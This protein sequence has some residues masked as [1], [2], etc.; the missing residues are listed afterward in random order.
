VIDS[1]IAGDPMNERIRWIKITREEVSALM[2]SEGISVSRNI[3]GKL[4]KAHKFVKRKMRGKL[5]CGDFPERN[6]QFEVIQDKLKRF[7]DSPNPVLSMDTKKKELLGRL[8]RPGKVYCSQAIEV[9]DHTNDSL[10]E[11][12]VVPHGIYD[13]KTGHAWINIGT[14]HE[15]AEFLCDSLKVWWENYGKAIYKQAEEILIFCDSGGANSWRI[16]V[17]KVELQKLCNVL[18]IRITICHY[19]PYASKW[20]PIEHRVF[21]HV[22]RAMEGVMLHS[23]E[24]VQSLIEKTTTKTGLKITANIIRKTYKIGKVVAKEALKYINIKYGDIVSGLNY[25]ISPK[26]T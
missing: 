6:Q 25:S 17:F 5:R 8:Y 16:N 7:K 3:V 2:K 23:H 20:N 18:N 11:G 15:T 22:N 26:I 21:P 1:H 4:L 24:Q 9:Y 14:T 13:L 19:P 12:N 10:I